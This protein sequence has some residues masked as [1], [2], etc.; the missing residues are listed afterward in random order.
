MKAHLLTWLAL[1]LWAVLIVAGGVVYFHGRPEP[2]ADIRQRLALSAEE[3]NDVLKEMRGMLVSLQGIQAGLAA[4][5]MG[6][7]AAA[8]KTSGMA[9]AAD[10]ALEAKLPAP[11]KNLATAAHTGFDEVVKAVSAGAKA[12]AI[13]AKLSAGLESCVACHATYRL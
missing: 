8:A 12:D 6:K 13:A 3:R 11:W 1:A 4:H 5:D 2:S 9:E 7:V 10:P